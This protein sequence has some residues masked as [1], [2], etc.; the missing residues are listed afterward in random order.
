M[1]SQS[2]TI[3]RWFGLTSPPLLADHEG[4]LC[5]DR[6]CDFQL[7]AN[8][9]PVL[10]VLTVHG[11]PAALRIHVVDPESGLLAPGSR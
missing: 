2:R 1:E 11:D 3:N 4:M 7:V 10:R 8:D 5:D 6:R 9:A